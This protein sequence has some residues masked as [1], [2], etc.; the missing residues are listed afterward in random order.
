MNFSHMIRISRYAEN[1]LSLIIKL[2]L[3][4]KL[5]GLGVTAAIW[6]F[7]TWQKVRRKEKLKASAEICLAVLIFYLVLAFF[8]TTISRS[9]KSF[10]D[11]NLHLFHTIR[12]VR[13]GSWYAVSMLFYNLALLWPLGLLGPPAMEYRCRWKD[14]LFLSFLISFSIE[15]TQYLFKLGYFE[16]DDILYNCFGALIGYIMGLA[17]KKLFVSVRTH[18]PGRR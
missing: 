15:C 8:I 16:A 12:E 9:P 7:L 6:L 2:P 18:E 17:V 13:A 14:I 3:R 1:G 11:I 10:R 4:L 5:F